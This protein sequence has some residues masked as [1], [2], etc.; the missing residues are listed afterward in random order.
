[1]AV[2]TKIKMLQIFFISDS[3]AF[4][5]AYSIVYEAG[6]VLRCLRSLIRAEK[7]QVLRSLV[8]AAPH[9]NEIMT[10][11]ARR[12]DSAISQSSKVIK[13]VAS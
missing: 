13:Y 4:Q 3:G 5:L 7:P 12:T 9:V 6:E 8:R 10:R 1:M 2:R 11:R